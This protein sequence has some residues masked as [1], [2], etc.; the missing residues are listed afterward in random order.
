MSYLF[1]SC[2]KENFKDFKDAGE[3]ILEYLHNHLG[4]AFAGNNV[5]DA[6]TLGVGAAI[7]LRKEDV[8]LKKNIDKALAEI[9]ADGTYKKLEKK[10]F[11]FSI[12]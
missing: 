7:G 3:K 5:V 1:L 6:K 10:Y 2:T 8:D 11:S 12:Y 9:I 4:F